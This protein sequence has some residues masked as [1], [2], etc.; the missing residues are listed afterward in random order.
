MI[1]N[2]QFIDSLANLSLNELTK[3]GEDATNCRRKAKTAEEAEQFQMAELAIRLEMMGRV[4]NARR[5]H[6]LAEL[7]IT[8][9]AAAA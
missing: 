9:E 6:V 1:A 2:A 4:A 8:R 7:R 3:V 5:E